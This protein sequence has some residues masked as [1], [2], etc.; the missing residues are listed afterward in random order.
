MSITRKS[1]RPRH[2]NE[3]SHQTLTCEISISDFLQEDKYGLWKNSCHRNIL[4]V[5]FFTGHKSSGTVRF[6]NNLLQDEESAEVSLSIDQQN[7][8]YCCFSNIQ[9]SRCMG[10]L[11]WSFPLCV[12]CF[13]NYHGSRDLIP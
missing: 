5:N 4:E 1:F 2:K 3:R 10:E 8:S 12:W 6:H 13:L 11:N 7:Y 9:Q